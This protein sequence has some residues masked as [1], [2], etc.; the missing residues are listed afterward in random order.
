M[1]K[2]LAIKDYP[3]DTFNDIGFVIVDECHNIATKEYSKHYKKLI[4]NI[5]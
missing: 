5:C 3:D 1:L 2:S 4:Q